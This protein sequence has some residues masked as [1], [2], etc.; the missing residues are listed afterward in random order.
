MC[1]LYVFSLQGDTDTGDPGRDIKK[2]SP[3]TDDEEASM[4]NEENLKVDGI[5]LEDMVSDYI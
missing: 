5:I 2:E 3:F 1:S 4:A